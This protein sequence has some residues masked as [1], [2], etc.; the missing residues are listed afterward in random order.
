MKNHTV[1]EKAAMR[2][3]TRE[4]A[5]KAKLDMANRLLEK[6]GFPAPN[7]KPEVK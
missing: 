3:K 4:D 6:A 2:N 7:K 5:V 1:P